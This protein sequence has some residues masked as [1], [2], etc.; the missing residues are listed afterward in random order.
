M[1]YETATQSSEVVG[2]GNS[3]SRKERAIGAK[4]PVVA[5]VVDVVAASNR[6]AAEVESPPSNTNAI[7]PK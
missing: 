3:K 6:E 4:R 1:G 2:N 7:N 5:I